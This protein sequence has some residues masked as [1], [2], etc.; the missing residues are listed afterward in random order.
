M[1]ED[2][3]GLAALA[4]GQAALVAALTGT[5]PT[6]PGFDPDRVRAA[7]RALLHKR[8]GSVA[9]AWPLLAAQFGPRFG[10]EFAT[11]AAGRPP[12]GALRDGWDLAAHLEARDELRGPARAELAT[13]RAALRYDGR[14]APAP[15]WAPWWGV[16]WGRSGRHAVLL[17]G[18]RRRRAIA[19]N[20]PRARVIRIADGML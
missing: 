12:A 5:G 13:R 19:V 1:T 18:R 20:G 8:A 15:R 16:G 7:R 14:S 10:A 9:A 4:A 11:W 6:P 17:L 3:D 2:P